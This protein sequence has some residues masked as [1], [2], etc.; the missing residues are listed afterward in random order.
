MTSTPTVTRWWWVRHA[1]MPP[2]AGMIHPPHAEPAPVPP[3][4]VEGLRRALPK[5]AL[6]LISGWARTRITARMLNHAPPLV[7]PE[8]AEQNFGDWTGQTHDDLALNHPEAHAAF[9]EDPAANAPPG[10][11]SFAEQ[12]GRVAAAIDRLGREH[13]GLDLVAVVHAGV[14]RAAVAH[15]LDLPAERALRLSIDPLSLTRIDWIGPHARVV[16]VNRT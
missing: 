5:R 1:A 10:G 15:A 6:W 7:V 11:E 13:A 2:P 8:L 4:L 12:C 3:P 16:A 14:I 9:W